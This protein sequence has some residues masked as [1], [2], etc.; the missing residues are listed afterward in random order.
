LRVF[1]NGSWRPTTSASAL[2][3]AFTTASIVEYDAPYWMLNDMTLIRIGEAMPAT[4]GFGRDR[5]VSALRHTT[6]TETSAK[7][8]MPR[9]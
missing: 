3:I 2:R 8:F 4:A 7:R 6:R 9:R 5:G 1:P